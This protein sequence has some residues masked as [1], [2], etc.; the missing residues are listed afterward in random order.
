M[1]H[2]MEHIQIPTLSSKPE[3]RD[4]CNYFTGF[5]SQNEIFSFPKFSAVTYNVT[6]L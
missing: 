2:G 6:D 3:I 4:V 5:S 1:P